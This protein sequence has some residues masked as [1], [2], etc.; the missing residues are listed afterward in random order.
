M[1]TVST[2]G[3]H[4][5]QRD[6]QFRIVRDPVTGMHSIRA[7]DEKNIIPVGEGWNPQ[8]TSEQEAMRF[9]ML[10]AIRRVGVEN[11]LSDDSVNVSLMSSMVNGLDMWRAT[12]LS[13]KHDQLLTTVSQYLGYSERKRA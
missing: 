12:L 5:S 7:W 8:F 6:I 13:F 10:R 11:I 2:F 4:T 9:A 3:L 1:K